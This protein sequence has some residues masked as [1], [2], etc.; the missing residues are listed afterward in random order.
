[1]ADELLPELDR[2]DAWSFWVASGDAFGADRV[3]IGTTGS[4][5]VTVVPDEGY[6]KV[7]MGKVRI[8]G[9]AL[10]VSRLKSKARKLK[11]KLA[12]LDVDTETEAIV[13]CT[14]GTIGSPKNVK[15]VWVLRPVDI[16][17]II[18]HRPSPVPRASAKKAAQS[19]GAKMRSVRPEAREG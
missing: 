7:S 15:G 11:A 14:Q 3:V 9:R 6:M 13:C 1:M 5:T 2:L 17:R 19:L 12:S 10:S 16:V 18:S 4:F 8:G